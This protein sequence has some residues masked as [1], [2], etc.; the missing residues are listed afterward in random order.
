MLALLFIFIFILNTTTAAT[1]NL[2][3]L[4]NGGAIQGGTNAEA[5]FWLNVPFAQPPLNE[6]RWRKPSYP[7]LKWNDTR[8][9][10]TLG[11][12][13]L[14]PTVLNSKKMPSGQ[15]DCLTLN[16]YAPLTAPTKLA[17]VVVYIP[18]GGFMTGN[19]FVGGLYNCSTLTSTTNMIYVVLQYRLGAFGFLAAPGINAEN[20]DTIAR[21][22]ILDQRA[23]LEFVRDNIY[24]FHGDKDQVTLWGESAGGG[25]VLLHLAL[26]ASWHLFHRIVAES[27]YFSP[28]G[29]YLTPENRWTRAKIQANALISSVG[30]GNT[31]NKSAAVAV[32]VA[33]PSLGNC[34][35]SISAHTINNLKVNQELLFEAPG[36][37]YYPVWSNDSQTPNPY[38]NRLRPNT[39]V[40]LGNN[41]N[42]SGLL[43]RML[44]P[45]MILPTSAQELKSAV[46]DLWGTNR[47]DSILQHYN[48]QADG[49]NNRAFF[50]AVSD[51]CINCPLRRWKN[52]LLLSNS[53][54]DVY[55]YIFD[56]MSI[57]GIGVSHTE[58]LPFVF[59]RQYMLLTKDLK[60]LSSQMVEMWEQFEKSGNPNGGVLSN[61][62]WPNS[63]NVSHEEDVMLFRAGKDASRVTTDL[64][65]RC[66]V[67]QD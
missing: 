37:N 64:F 5:R 47:S 21:L 27:P 42:E 13:C 61:V 25:S 62:T 43:S 16:I 63:N 66:F 35:R 54:A 15:E 7:A 53:S 19:S 40:L 44:H 10:T 34:M 8:D 52:R 3:T 28:T 33:P 1:N 60:V 46:V 65:T 22:G 55:Q 67:W 14:G 31:S 32:T 58:E 11:P 56:A 59:D 4:S 23:A 36:A 51:A 38:G 30:C 20:D 39:S 6:L 12:K 57:P 45:E 26:E 49:K 29:M 2:V 41:M 50:A 24:L 48:E 17:P 9:A 18:G